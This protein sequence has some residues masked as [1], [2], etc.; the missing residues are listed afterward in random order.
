[1][2]DSK[3]DAPL[4]FEGSVKSVGT[5]NV[6]SV[7][8]DRK[9]AVVTVDHVRH[10]PR[11]MAGLA[12]KEI[13]VRMA[14]GETLKEG[15]QFTFFADSLVF[16][17][18]LAVQSRGHEAVVPAEKAAAVMGAAPV[19][20]RLKRRIDEAEAVVSG[21]VVDIRPT[22]TGGP[23]SAARA[24]ANAPI[25]RISEHEPFWQEAVIEVSGVHKGPKQRRVVVRFPSSTDVHWHKAP[26]FKKGQS[27]IWLLH[28]PPQFAALAGAQP[29]SDVYTALDP[30]D[31]QPA[32]LAPVVEAMLPGSS[33]ADMRKRSGVK[34]GPKVA[35][36]NRTSTKRAV[37][38]KATRR[39]QTKK[40]R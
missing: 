13:T 23:K 37:S 3:V 33:E 36:T 19:V 27:G 32:S 15:D 38:K 8:A 6:N 30:D 14:P 24:A 16:G 34:P 25:E 9:T 18:N 39:T 26:K 4:V 5:S 28:S 20:Q 7:P 22:S 12:G 35:V 11:V 17:D 1:M 29:I 2:D 10:A 31:Y 21:R 40:R